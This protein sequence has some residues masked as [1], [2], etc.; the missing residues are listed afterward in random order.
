MKALVEKLAKMELDIATKKGPF[1]LFA[2]FLREDAP[3][4]WDLLVSAPWVESDKM[5]SFKYLTNKLKSIATPQ[6]LIQ[7]SRIVAIDRNDPALSAINSAFSV[8]HKILEI[9]D[10]NLFGLQ[11]KHAYLITSHKPSI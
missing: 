8:E 2:L 3:D 7:L 1:L 6:E 4:V 11:I 5:G 9:K 10:A